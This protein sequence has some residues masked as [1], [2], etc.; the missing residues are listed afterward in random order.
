MVKITATTN[1]QVTSLVPTDYT[2]A[3]KAL[4][5]RTNAELNQ[6]WDNTATPPALNT[7]AT[8]TS[9]AV[10]ARRAGSTITFVLSVTLP[11]AQK[12]AA[13]A[14]VSAKMNATAFVAKMDAVKT[15]NTAT[16]ANVTVPAASAVTTNTPLATAVDVVSSAATVTTSVMAMAVAAL[17]AFQARQ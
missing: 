3:T 17:A 9:S 2:G 13:Y 7:A 5:E 1:M 14:I 12:A 16:Y 11:L 6:L 4:Y 10:S 8:Q 15:A